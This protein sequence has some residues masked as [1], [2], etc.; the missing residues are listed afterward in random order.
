MTLDCDGRLFTCGT[1]TGAPKSLG[2]V[3]GEILHFGTQHEIFDG[4]GVNLEASVEICRPNLL[5]HLQTGPVS[6]NPCPEIDKNE[7]LG[8]QKCEKLKVR[9]VQAQFVQ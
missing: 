5:S 7:C 4:I 2:V 8:R 1:S 3:S 6:K 9:T